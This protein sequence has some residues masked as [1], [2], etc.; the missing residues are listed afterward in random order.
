MERDGQRD[1][2]RQDAGEEDQGGP[3]LWHGEGIAEEQERADEERERHQ[4]HEDLHDL[5]LSAPER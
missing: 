5:S 2:H 3:G 1:A 4:E